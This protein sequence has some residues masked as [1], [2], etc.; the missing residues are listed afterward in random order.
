VLKVDGAFGG[1]EIRF[2]LAPLSGRCLWFIIGPCLRFIL[3][4]GVPAALEFGSGRVGGGPDVTSAGGP[5]LVSGVAC[6]EPLP[7]GG[8]LPGEGVGTGRPGFVM[9]HLDVCGLL[10][11]VGF[12]LR[13]EAQGS[14]DVGR[15]AGLD[16]FPSEDPGFELAA[17]QGTDDVGFVADLERSKYCLT[18]QA[19]TSI[20]LS[21]AWAAASS[22]QVCL[23]RRALPV[24]GSVPA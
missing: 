15:R 14:A 9:L 16:A 1:L 18:P 4:L 12:G 7:F 13:G 6:L 2:E 8:Q 17:V 21:A 11:G 23:S 22:G 10:Q 24:T 5:R 19:S 3:R 20:R